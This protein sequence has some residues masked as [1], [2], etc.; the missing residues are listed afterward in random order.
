MAIDLNGTSCLLAGIAG[1]PPARVRQ[2]EREP[3]VGK[4]DEERFNVRV[5]AHPFFALSRLCRR[6]ACD[7]GIKRRV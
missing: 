3:S 5:F 7:P 6:D 1:V 2:H 4:Q